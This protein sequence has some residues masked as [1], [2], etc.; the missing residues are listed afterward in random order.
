MNQLARYLVS[1]MG[2]THKQAIQANKQKSC[3]LHQQLTKVHTWVEILPFTHD[4]RSFRWLKFLLVTLI[5]ISCFLPNIENLS[6][7][8][9]FLTFRFMCIEPILAFSPKQ[10]L[11]RHFCT[12][13]FYR[14]LRSIRIRLCCLLVL[15]MDYVYI[16]DVPVFKVPKAWPLS[17]F[18]ITIF[19][20]GASSFC[21]LDRQ[22]LFFLEYVIATQIL[23]FF[24]H[25]FMSY[26]W[27]LGKVGR[28]D[29]PYDNLSFIC[30]EMDLKY[31]HYS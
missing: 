24:C 27:I 8:S 29:L 21:F 14:G 5:L 31:Y 12:S 10:Y 22:L 15:Q 16:L 30:K 19:F 2:W 23:I 28:G 18:T 25:F 17:Y 4:L 9:H 3:R 20:S 26:L 6:C 13:W 7:V 11:Q 1:F